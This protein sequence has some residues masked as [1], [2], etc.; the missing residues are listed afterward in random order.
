MTPARTAAIALLAGALLAS[1]A[2]VASA[3]PIDLDA[4]RRALA[5]IQRQ[6]E[7]S[8]AAM[9]EARSAALARATAT[10][11]ALREVRVGDAVYTAPP[12]GTIRALLAR[13]DD[14]SLALAAGVLSETVAALERPRGP[15]APGGPGLDPERARR[16]LEAVFEGAD[17]ERVPDWRD[18]LA[19]LLRRVIAAIFPDLRAPIIGQEWVT[20]ALAPVAVALLALVLGVSGGGLR[21]RVRREVALRAA[22]GAPRSAARDHLI[23]AEA[24]LHAGRARDAVRGLFLFA[25]FALEERELLRVDPALTDRELLARAAGLASARDLAN[26]VD[27][28]ERAWYGVREPSAAE[29]ARARE[30]AQRIAA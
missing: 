18:A 17:F 3:E 14:A 10:L 8:R 25:L 29:V 30:L 21:E 13:G 4:Y 20:L 23:A 19:E 11:D 28:Y 1:A 22:A 12:H 16:L 9:G 6:V 5:E 15:G 27:V 24:A 7:A 2:G 26:L